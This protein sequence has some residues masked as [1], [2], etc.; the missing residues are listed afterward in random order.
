MTL[1]SILWLLACLLTEWHDSHECSALT[2]SLNYWLT[3]M[4]IHLVQAYN[5]AIGAC[6]ETVNINCGSMPA[7]RSASK[8]VRR[9]RMIEQSCKPSEGEGSGIVLADAAS[10]NTY[11]I[12]TYYVY[13]YTYMREKERLRE[14]LTALP[15][16]GLT[17]HVRSIALAT[18]YQHHL[19]HLIPCVTAWILADSF[20]AG[21]HASRFTI[22][23]PYWMLT[24]LHNHMLPWRPT[25]L[26]DQ[27]Q[28]KR[29]C[30]WWANTFSCR[31]VEVHV[32]SMAPQRG[33]PSTEHSM[34]RLPPEFHTDWETV[35]Y[36]LPEVSF[37]RFNDRLD[38]FNNDFRP[39][40]YA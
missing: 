4:H 2:C 34:T 39:G 9:G 28:T 30:S 16:P 17:G 15:Y 32:S 10:P 35:Y 14:Y 3:R 31:P 21:L 5:R 11:T 7:S 25:V 38:W 36:W 23:L 24:C 22:S 1:C 40:T 8:Q 37:Q 29:A 33:Q 6:G 20:H 13:V 18:T 12:C 27:V 19:T 26:V